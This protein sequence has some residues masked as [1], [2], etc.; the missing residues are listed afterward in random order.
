MFV[1]FVVGTA[2]ENAYDLTGVF[3]IARELRDKGALEP[4]EV[5]SLNESFAWFNANLPC[6]PFQEKRKKKQWSDDAV[7]WFRC[8]AAEPLKRIWD[9]VALLKENG[10][11]VRF[12]RTKRPRRIVYEDQYQIVAETPSLAEQDDRL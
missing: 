2:A 11:P 6:P 10:V 7:S 5:D 1:R 4:H 9:I 8:D 3:T 12:V